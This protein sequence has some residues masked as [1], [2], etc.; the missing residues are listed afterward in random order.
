VY[1][2][3]SLLFSY[4]NLPTH[5]PNPNKQGNKPNPGIINQKDKQPPEKEKE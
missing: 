1:R 5:N 3:A 4:Q 2:D